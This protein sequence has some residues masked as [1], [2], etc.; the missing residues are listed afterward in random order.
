MK[1]EELSPK[2]RSVLKGA[3]WS[4]PVIA[5]AIAAPAASASEV[6]E[7]GQYIWETSAA[8]PTGS[9]IDPHA[10][11][12][13]ATYSSQASWAPDPWANVPTS[14]TMTITVAFTAPV[15][16]A[17]FTSTQPRSLVSGDESRTTF[18]FVA[19]AGQNMNLS[20]TFNGAASGT[21]GAVSSMALTPS[22][23]ATWESPTTAEDVTLIP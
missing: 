15:T 7:G 9:K 6:A 21:I 2:R 19:P 13:A 4:T 8:N 12:N 22:N 1:T 5:A 20:F 3:A 10:S 14:A 17:N 18:V 23:A 11:G 16:F